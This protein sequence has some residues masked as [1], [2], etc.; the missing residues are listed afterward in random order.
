MIFPDRFLISFQKSSY[1]HPPPRDHRLQRCALGVLIVVTH[2]NGGETPRCR[3]EGG[4]P[5]VETRW[6]TGVTGGADHG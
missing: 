3:C 6:F 2:G 4:A 1:F 5:K